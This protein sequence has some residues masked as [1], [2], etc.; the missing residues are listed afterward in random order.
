MTSRKDPVLRGEIPA[1]W[2]SLLDA[3]AQEVFGTMLGC[4]L[5]LWR[6]PAST[7]D[8]TAIVG[9]AGQLCGVVTVCCTQRS[10]ALIASKMLGVSAEHARDHM[11]DAIGEI[12]N[13]IAG[14]FKNKL[15]N[16]IDNCWV[17]VP[18]VIS[19]SNYKLQPLGNAGT[20]EIQFD[21]EGEALIVA[22]DIH[23]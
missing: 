1:H 20:L 8:L 21:F 9:L 4:R 18:T 10:A 2:P 5:S 11:W 14:N 15:P 3:A 23:S 6:K 19:G 13:I 12:C 17:S 16:L 7:F 22:L